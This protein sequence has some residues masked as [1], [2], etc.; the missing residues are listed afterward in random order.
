EPVPP[1][2][3]RPAPVVAASAAP[4]PSRATPAPP[5]AVAERPPLPDMPEI[6]EYDDAPPWADE[7]GV[8]T[9]APAVAPQRAPAAVPSP[10]L[11]I[12]G[13]DPGPAS[14]RVE[15]RDSDIGAGPD[16]SRLVP[17]PEGDFWHE[18]V[19]QLVKA[20][21][22]TA[23]V[24]ELGLQSQLMARS[25]E[26]WRLRIERGSLA[27]GSSC[28]RLAAALATLGHAGVKIAVDVVE[29]GQV[30]DSPALRQAAE[31]QRRQRE[32]EG[33]ILDDPFVQA[34]MRDFGGKIVPGSLK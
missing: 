25:P 26:A 12:P 30:T 13:R 17:T 23:L 1:P 20:E 16:P 21:A 31:A 18:T 10:V 6:E 8:A 33:L 34:M 24:R 32:A 2:A 11:A 19:T 22:I 29:A 9:S 7:G 15:Q 4:A 3:Q 27:Q 5:S 14:D 28:E